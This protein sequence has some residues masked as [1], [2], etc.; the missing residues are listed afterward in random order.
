MYAQVRD[1]EASLHEA[2]L[3]S[4]HDLIAARAVAAGATG[5]AYHTFRCLIKRQQ[6]ALGSRSLQISNYFCFF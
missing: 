1:V 4:F 5:K 2:L 6:G 3:D